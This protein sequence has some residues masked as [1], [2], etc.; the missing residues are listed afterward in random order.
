M[1]LCTIDHINGLITLSVITLSGFHCILESFSQM[2]KRQI[3][4]NSSD[5]K[6]ERQK[7][8]KT[9]RQKDGKT[10]RQKDRKT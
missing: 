5:R 1:G 4:R 2:R 7:D 10:E 8:R 3:E 9:E 6:T